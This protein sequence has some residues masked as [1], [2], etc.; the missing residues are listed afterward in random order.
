[1]LDP[2]AGFGFLSVA[3]LLLIGQRLA[4]IPFFADTVFHM[5][6]DF[7]AD[8][9]TV[10]VNNLVFFG[11]KIGELVAVILN[12]ITTSNGGLPALLFRSL[13]NAFSSKGRNA[14]K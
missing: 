7:F 4:A 9:R 1:M 10:R 2:A 11:E 3:F 14:S 12:I 6:G 8:I 5:G 13:R